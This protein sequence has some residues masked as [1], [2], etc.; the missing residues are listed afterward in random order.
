M[1]QKRGILVGMRKYRE[2]VC[3]LF[4]TKKDQKVFGGQYRTRTYDPLGVNEMLY[5]LS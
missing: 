5:Q 1:Q 3:L 2:S 4:E